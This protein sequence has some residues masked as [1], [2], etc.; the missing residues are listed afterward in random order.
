[1]SEV[2]ELEQLRRERDELKGQLELS[3]TTLEMKGRCDRCGVQWNPA[4]YGFCPV[5]TMD[6]A[7]ESLRKELAAL[8][9][10]GEKVPH[11]EPTDEGGI[12]GAVIG[13]AISR[14]LS[15]CFGLEAHIYCWLNGCT[16]LPK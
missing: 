14:W 15:L 6:I 1:V 11:V 12:W 4:N 3:R 9:A 16:V 13:W 2:D 10:W 8:T 5:C 7:N